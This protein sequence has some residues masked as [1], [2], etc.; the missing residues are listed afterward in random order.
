MEQAAFAPKAEFTDPDSFGTVFV[1]DGLEFNLREALKRG[2][3]YIIT[4]VPAIISRLST[5]EPLESVPVDEAREAQETSR[6][7]AKPQ[8]AAK[9]KSKD[10]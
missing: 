4:D 7:A 9:P 1:N 5:Y 3:G 10:D 8:P 2:K 6:P